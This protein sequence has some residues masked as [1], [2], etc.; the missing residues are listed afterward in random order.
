[1][2][3][4]SYTSILNSSCVIEPLRISKEIKPLSPKDGCI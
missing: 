3:T 2:D 1:L 4:R